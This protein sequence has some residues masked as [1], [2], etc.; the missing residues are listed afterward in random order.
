MLNYGR[1]IFPYVTELLLDNAR[2]N[3][4]RRALLSEVSGEVL[5]IGIGSGLN[6][7]CY[8]PG[9][10]GVVGLDPS[11]Q[12]LD[13]AHK[14]IQKVP[15]PVVIVPGTAEQMDFQGKTFDAVVLTWTLCSVPSPA[16]TLENMRRVLRPYGRL[17]FLEHGL[18][19]DH[20]VRRLQHLWAPIHRRLCAGCCL[21]VAVDRE[22]EK[23]GFA[24]S[25]LWK[26]YISRPK[27]LT[28]VYEGTARCA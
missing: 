4:R 14:R 20:H 23:A 10:K 26:G 27:I 13:L 16:L 19:P 17:Y 11:E 18:S 8:G 5:E 22:I 3:A 7:P 9:V 24:M 2:I 1:D 25:S 6:L 15:F 28:Y 21:T 12:A